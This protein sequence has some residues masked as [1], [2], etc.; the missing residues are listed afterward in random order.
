[1]KSPPTLFSDYPDKMLVRVAGTDSVTITG[2]GGIV[3]SYAVALDNK[4]NPENQPE[5]E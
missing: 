3:E 1:M 5:E 2:T 4:L